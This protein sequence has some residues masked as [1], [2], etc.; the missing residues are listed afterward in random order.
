LAL[1]G[2]FLFYEK[3]RKQQIVGFTVV[4]TGFVLFYYEQLKVVFS[5]P[6]DFNKGAFLLLLGG[7]TWAI[8]AIIQKK[9]VQKYPPQTLNL[10]MYGLATLLYLPFIHFS[11]LGSLSVGWWS[12]L[13]FLGANTLIAYGCM[14][15]SLKYI[16]ANKVS[17]III[18]NPIITFIIMAMLTAL[19]VDWIAPEHFTP[20]AWTGAFMFLIGAFLVVKAGKK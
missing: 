12:L 20:L 14:N 10:F 15:A 9:L 16:D 3:V 17:A 4:V 7:F 8:Y 13:I 11:A 6:G 18:N 1:A 19:D 5:A 2:I